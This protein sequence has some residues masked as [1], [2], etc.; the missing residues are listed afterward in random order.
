MTLTIHNMYSIAI[1]IT[2]MILLEVNKS[3][4]IV[5]MT[6]FINIYNG[7]CCKSINL[8]SKILRWHHKV[9]IRLCV[10]MYTKTWRKK[11]T[12]I[13]GKCVSHLLESRPVVYG[14]ETINHSGQTFLGIFPISNILSMSSCNIEI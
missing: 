3:V 7:S 2:G 5:L 4:L 9:F 12:P 13:F 6:I 1:R 11:I 8:F 10:G 14:R